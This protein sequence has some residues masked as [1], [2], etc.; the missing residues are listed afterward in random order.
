MRL[1]EPVG[2]SVATLSLAPA[3]PRPPQRPVLPSQGRFVMLNW[4]ICSVMVAFGLVLFLPLDAGRTPR[5]IDHG[6]PTHAHRTAFWLFL[7]VGS[8]AAGS[9]LAKE[10]WLAGALVGWLTLMSCISFSEADGHGTGTRYSV[11]LLAIATGGTC[12][13][14]L[15]EAGYP[16]WALIPWLVTTVANGVA[17]MPA[18]TSS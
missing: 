15:S 17:L 12:T 14:W 13:I 10:R 4:L 2:V 5:I 6:F 9:I 16:Y 11:S 18:R 3:V 1:P 8:V 7:L